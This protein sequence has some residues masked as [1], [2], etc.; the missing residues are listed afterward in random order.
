MNGYVDIQ[1]KPEE[2]GPRDKYPDLIFFPSPNS[3]WVSHDGTQL[4]H[5]LHTAIPYKDSRVERVEKSLCLGLSFLF[6]SVMV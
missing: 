3:C 1:R 6:W 2:N 4:V 5:M